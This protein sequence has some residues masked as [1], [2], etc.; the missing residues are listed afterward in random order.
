MVHHLECLKRAQ[1]EIDAVVGT[2][3]FPTIDD[4]EQLPYMTCMV[5]ETF[6]YVSVSI[7]IAP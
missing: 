7:Y 5:H 1:Q 2:E 6:R 3:R 4:R